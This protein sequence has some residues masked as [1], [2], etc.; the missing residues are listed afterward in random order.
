VSSN[1]FTL[2]PIGDAAFLDPSPG[3]RG[4]QAKRLRAHLSR[5][6]QPPDC[7]SL[8]GDR[9][10]GKTSLLRHLYRATAKVP[11]AHTAFLDLMGL[12]E[13]SSDGFF[14]LLDA[15]LRRTAGAPLRGFADLMAFLDRLALGDERV[16]LFLD[17]F[18]LLAGDHR[19]DRH[20]FNQLRAAAN[21]LP[22][23][24]VI[25][26][27]RPLAEI[28][29]PELYESPFFNIF[30]K[31]R[32]V[33]L[34]DAEAE[35]LVGRAGTTQHT[36]ADLTGPIL[37]LAGRHP[38]LLQLA[39]WCAWELRARGRDPDVNELRAAFL[40]RQETN[41]YY[42]WVWGHSSDDERRGL[43]C[44]VP[45]SRGGGPGLAWPA[46][47]PYAADG[48]VRRACGS[49]FVE[50]VRG[51]CTE[52]SPCPKE[53]I[54][55]PPAPRA[56]PS[57]P[58]AVPGAAT[59]RVA[60]VVGVNRYLHAG[61]SALNLSPLQY[62]EADA[63]VLAAFLEKE[64]EFEVRCLVGASATAA[65]LHNAFA[66]VEEKTAGGGRGDSCFVF[67]FSGH[68]MLDPTNEER[69]YLMLHDSEPR[70]PA[71]TGLEMAQLVLNHLSRVK[72]PNALMLLDACHAGLAAGVRTLSGAPS[73]QLAA[74]A[75]QLV[76]GLR[77][78]MILV[79]CAG[80]H[81]AREED[82]LGHGVFTHYVL[83]H[84]RDRDGH[85]FPEGVTFDSLVR[86]VAAAMKDHRP[87]VPLPVYSGTGEGPFV[88]L[89]PRSP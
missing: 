74:I 48:D 31:E 57:P 58:H 43:C 23:T 3:G 19:F 54:D 86:Y 72:V 60:L 5:T 11:G 79:A 53:P 8:L 17:E 39:C 47:R 33:L 78:R 65:A 70:R 80:E 37:D 82:R 7:V 9:R 85:H 26:S 13:P 76:G 32:L 41:E 40:E 81:L 55:P 16:I 1:P 35:A 71:E 66:W 36:L 89:R 49:V 84:W 63:R 25:A 69:A 28:A 45:G 24:L 14:A 29:H 20:F 18:D 64:L 56:F 52:W 75:Q 6:D 22:L 68:G 4:W 30:F 34:S 67:H 38:F 83:R 61:D 10:F 87:S 62:A 2:R 46:G 42:Q 15:A 88:V 73:G 21:G 27:V 12:P 51:R 59:R 50:F 77:G 44:Q